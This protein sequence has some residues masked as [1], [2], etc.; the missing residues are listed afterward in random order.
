LGQVVI[1]D[2]GIMPNMPHQFVLLHDMFGVFN[3]QPQHREGF[4][5]QVNRLVQA[6][7]YLFAGVEAK[8]A[9]IVDS[10]W[11]FHQN[12]LGTISELFQDFAS[13]PNVIRLQQFTK[14]VPESRWRKFYADLAVNAIGKKKSLLF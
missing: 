7:Q 6:K 10:S 2:N 5:R 13:V 12:F 11:D 9:E 8:V 4:Q 3:E 1:F 14:G